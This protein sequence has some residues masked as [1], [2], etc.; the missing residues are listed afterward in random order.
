MSPFYICRPPCETQ[1]GCMDREPSI[2]YLFYCQQDLQQCLVAVYKYKSSQM[3]DSESLLP[4]E[5]TSSGELQNGLDS[6]GAADP[7]VSGHER[8]QP[9]SHT[10]TMPFASD[11]STM[12]MT[13]TSNQCDNNF[14]SWPVNSAR[15]F[16]MRL[17]SQ[18]DRHYRFQTGQ[19]YVMGGPS[20][21]CRVGGSLRW[22][23]RT[24]L[25]ASGPLLRGL[26]LRQPVQACALLICELYCDV[27]RAMQLL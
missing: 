7:A 22:S 13:L 1:S 18:N 3:Q 21:F 26:H 15:S 5:V 16:G 10:A 23:Q 12:V 2:I 17:E 6:Q 11:S 14:R 4:K 19:K 27:S 25:S 20:P 9:P 8:A 24:L